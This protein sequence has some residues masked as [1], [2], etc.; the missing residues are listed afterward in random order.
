MNDEK[1]VRLW[2]DHLAFSM[3]RR[4]G[5][6]RLYSRYTTPRSLAFETQS[7]RGV[8]RWLNKWMREELERLG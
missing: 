5:V 3:V 6:Y 2:A 8:V 1:S 4:G 7:L